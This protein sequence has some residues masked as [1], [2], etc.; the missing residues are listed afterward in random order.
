M[1]F[2]VARKRMRPPN[3]VKVQATRTSPLRKKLQ[4][5][6]S[7]I[8]PSQSHPWTT[9]CVTLLPGH[10]NRPRAG[11]FG[12]VSGFEQMGKLICTHLSP[13]FFM[14]YG[15]MKHIGIPKA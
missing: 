14:T 15:L 4:F 12:T 2:A 6:C 13:A 9:F 11:L 10:P 5:I 8:E 1:K 3:R 7:L